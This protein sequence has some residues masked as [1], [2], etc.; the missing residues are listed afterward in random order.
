MS[1]IIGGFF[2]VKWIKMLFEA[3]KKRRQRKVIAYYEREWDKKLRG[4]K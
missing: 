3:N 2:L 1:T 4:L